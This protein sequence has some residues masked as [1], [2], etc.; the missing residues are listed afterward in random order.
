[1]DDYW[2]DDEFEEIAEEVLMAR[3]RN[4]TKPVMT[5][6]PYNSG[7]VVLNEP[8]AP[9]TVKNFQAVLEKSHHCEDIESLNAYLN[10]QYSGLIDKKKAD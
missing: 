2:E 4:T 8:V 1:M 6:I 7:F 5:V 3:G 9:T 10:I